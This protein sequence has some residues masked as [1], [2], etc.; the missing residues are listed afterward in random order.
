METRRRC[1][2][3]VAHGLLSIGLSILVDVRLVGVLLVVVMGVGCATTDNSRVSSTTESAGESTELDVAALASFVEERRERSFDQTLQRHNASGFQLKWFDDDDVPIVE[4]A[5]P[6][7]IADLMP[8][9][10][11]TESDWTM[12]R[13]L[14]VVPGDADRDVVN[15]QLNLAVT[16]RCCPIL[17]AD[18]DKHI[19][20]AAVVVHELTH[21]IEWHDASFPPGDQLEWLLYATAAFEGNADRIRGEYLDTIGVTPEHW[22]ELNPPAA[23]V[24]HRL[25]EVFDFPYTYG[26]E[27][28][29]AV[30]D[31]GDEAAIDAT[32]ATPP[33]SAKQVMFPDA[34]FASS[35]PVAVESAQPTAGPVTDRAGE[36]GAFLL[37]LAI[38]DS[39]G[40]ETAERIVSE[41]QGDSYVVSS[42]ANQVCLDFRVIMSSSSSADELAEAL[43]NSPARSEAAFQVSVDDDTVDAVRC[44][45]ALD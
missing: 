43:T 16:G 8:P 15:R 10:P 25:S 24:P 21:L 12:L 22:T 17:V 18:A 23:G 45:D 29:G 5:S 14:D 1:R 32:L 26:A 36:L 42:S 35:T 3:V 30:D 13:L 44:L 11:T 28:M 2:R 4:L 31:R 38:L 19:V 6:T 37:Y 9:E 27:F 20:E 41:W 39:V 34:Y 7:E 40:E 33:V